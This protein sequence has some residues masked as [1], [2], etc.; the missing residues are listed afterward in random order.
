M[1]RKEE[2]WR[3]WW[4]KRRSTEGEGVQKGLERGGV[5]DSV[6]TFRKIRTIDISCSQDC[7]SGGVR[8]SEPTDTSHLAIQKI[9][10]STSTLFR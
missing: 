2:R 3:S 4:K 5:E 7:I 6:R 8:G 1:K 9:F 10:Y